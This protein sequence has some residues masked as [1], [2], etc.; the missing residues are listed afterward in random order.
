MLAI[1]YLIFMFQNSYYKL[2]LEIVVFSGKSKFNLGCWKKNS[3]LSLPE[4]C[5]LTKLAYMNIPQMDK[6]MYDLPSKGSGIVSKHYGEKKKKRRAYFCCICLLCCFILYRGFLYVQLFLLKCDLS[7]CL[8]LFS[9]WLYSR[10][11]KLCFFEM[12]SLTRPNQ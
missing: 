10:M 5:I 4:E 12:C 1:C 9:L 3:R 11:N 8:E 6:S 7:V 2:H